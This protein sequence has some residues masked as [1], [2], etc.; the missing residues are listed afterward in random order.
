MV[1]RTVAEIAA[2]LQGDSGL[3]VV[4]DPAIVAAIDAEFQRKVREATKEATR[5][6]LGLTPPPRVERGSTGLVA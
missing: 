3:N 4:T 6:M 5:Q 2:E 1:T